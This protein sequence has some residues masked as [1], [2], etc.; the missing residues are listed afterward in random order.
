M[1]RDDLVRVTDRGLYC[2][3][4][5]LHIDPWGPVERAV[6]T[7]AHADHARPGSD[8]YLAAASGEAILRARLGDVRLET[9]AWG[10]RRRLGDVTL[11]LHPA[12][13][14]RGS[15]QVR[16]ERGGEVWVVTG[17]YK[18]HRDPVAEPFELVPCHTLVSECTFGL[19]VYRWPDPEGVY[20]A[21]DDWWRENR[22]AGRTSVLFGYAL[23]KAQHLLAA[24][25]ASAGPILVH[26][27]VQRMNEAHEAAGVTLPETRYAGVDEAKATRGEALVIAP[28]SSGGR[29]GWMRKFGP[30]STAFASGW[31]QVRGVRR[32][33]AADR[34]FV[35]SDHADWPGILEVVR[36]T[37]AERV[38]LTHGK[39]GPM[40][41]YLREEGWDAWSLPTRYEG[42]ADRAEGAVDEDVTAAGEERRAGEGPGS[43]GAPRQGGEDARGGAA[44]GQ[45][46]DGAG[47]RSGGGGRSGFGDDPGP[48]QLPLESPPAD[49]DAS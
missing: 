40:V 7:H 5:D 49:G 20:R 44:G 41:R 13:H 15:A 22:E 14:V 4:A 27:A 30:T 23:G 8:R 34:G 16:L 45:G 32:R 35:L 21:I 19:P 10:E 1:S 42:E 47:G 48:P 25:D 2:P 36:E 24:V 37:G 26:G 46:G 39:T 43:S 17:D 29:P 33:R 9:V 38:G 6:V 11:S 12:G 3:A 18:V 28:P 31:M